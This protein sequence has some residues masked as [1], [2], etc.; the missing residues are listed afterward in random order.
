MRRARAENFS[1]R[2][3]V[4]FGKRI[5]LYANELKPWNGGGASNTQGEYVCV[6][7]AELAMPRVREMAVRSGKVVP[8]KAG[9]S[10]GYTRNQKGVGNP[11]ERWVPPSRRDRFP[12]N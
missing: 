11:L 9:Q 8:P 10:R 3:A 6:R 5:V 2:G 1:V 4:K 12:K 7:M